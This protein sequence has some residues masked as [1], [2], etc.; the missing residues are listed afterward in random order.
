MAREDYLDDIATANELI[1]EFGQD[2][3]WQKPAPPTGGGSAGYPVAGALPQPV[4][5]RI[6][7][8][9][10][11]D[12]DSGVQQAMD[13]IAGTEVSDNTEIGLMAGDVPFTPEN[14]DQVRRGAVDAE[15]ISIV[16]MDKLAPNGTPV[17]YYVMVA[18]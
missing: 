14:I 8:F 12:L 2:C 7:F 18:A 6:A 1:D 4:P 13:M 16:K 3:W 17:L 9:R 5:V 15:P 11:K 10:P